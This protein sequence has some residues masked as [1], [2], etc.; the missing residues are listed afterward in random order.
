[1]YKINSVK[2]ICGGLYTNVNR[3]RH[4]KTKRHMK[5]IL[6]YNLFRKIKRSL[7]IIFD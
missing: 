2:C 1:M 6:N 4:N 5:F 3:I 7:I